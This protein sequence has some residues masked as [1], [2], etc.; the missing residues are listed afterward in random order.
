M[1]AEHGL[2]RRQVIDNA[3]G[4]IYGEVLAIPRVTHVALSLL[5]VVLSGCTLYLAVAVEWTHSARIA[6]VFTADASDDKP[7]SANLYVPASLRN[8]LF[9]DRTYY[10]SID[11][12]R[13]Q[14]WTT[15]TITH[16]SDR[17]IARCPICTKSYSRDEPYVRVEAIALDPMIRLDNEWLALS[18]DVRFHFD[19]ELGKQTAWKLLSAHF[20]QRGHST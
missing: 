11:G 17:V 4:R 18:N 3:G 7:I 9:V 20:Q 5:F 19:L 8:R 2:F 13:N 12:L 1:T 6:G 14:A 16:V 10:V 15:I